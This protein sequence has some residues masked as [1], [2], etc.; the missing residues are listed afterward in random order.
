MENVRAKA[1]YRLALPSD[2][3]GIAGLLSGCGLPLAGAREHIENFIV[4]VD[5]LGIVGCAGLEIYGDTGLLRSVAVAESE[6]GC[7]Y[8]Q[9]L[10]ERVLLRAQQRNVR[11]VVVMAGSAEEFFRRFEFEEIRLDR[12][13]E[14]IRASVELRY[15]EDAASSAMLL[16]LQA[17]HS[18]WPV[19]V[20][21][22]K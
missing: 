9:N 10:V 21:M 19:G 1:A 15:T 14:S 22:A 18:I 7:G 4:A 8:G 20:P 2:W 12:L 16:N 5:D 6:R 13:P 11:G 17:V 3:P